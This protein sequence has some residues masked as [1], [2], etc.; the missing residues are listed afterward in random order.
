MNSRQIQDGLPRF[1]FDLTAQRTR[2]SGE[3]D[4][5]GHLV[6][7]NLDIPDHVQAD[8]I[9]MKLW[10]LYLAEGGEY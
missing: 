5:E 6:C 4:R 9:F 1:L 10:L 8:K 2:W 3:D 7:F